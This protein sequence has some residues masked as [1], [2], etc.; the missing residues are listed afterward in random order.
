VSKKSAP[1]D[2]DL[3][4]EGNYDA[5]RRYDQSAHEFA[6]SGQVDERARAARPAS[7]EEADAMRRAEQEGKSHSKGEDAAPREQ[8]KR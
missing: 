2:K 5:T 8:P 4:G 7:P 1:K 3:Q 6:K